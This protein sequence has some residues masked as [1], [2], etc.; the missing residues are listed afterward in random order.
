[1]CSETDED[2]QKRFSVT[3]KAHS[4]IRKVT[5]DPLVQVPYFGISSLFLDMVYFYSSTA[6]ISSTV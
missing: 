3:S 1:V 2:F 4:F 5:Y 6:R